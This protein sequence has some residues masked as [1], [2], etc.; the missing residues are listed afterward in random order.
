MVVPKPERKLRLCGNY[1][2]TINQVLEPDKDAL[3]EDLFTAITRENK[4]T[5][6]DLREAYLQMELEEES[7]KYATII[8]HQG[9]YRYKCLPFR[10]LSAPTLF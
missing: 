7:Q 9:L 5:K 8:T 6:M 3:P 2:V 1:K 10:I 4:F